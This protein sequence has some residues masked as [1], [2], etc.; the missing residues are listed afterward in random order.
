MY[1]IYLYL[2]ASYFGVVHGT[3]ARGRR[4]LINLNQYNIVTQS[5]AL[6]TRKTK[7]DTNITDCSNTLEITIIF[8]ILM[9]LKW[10]EINVYVS[11]TS[12]ASVSQ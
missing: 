2:I 4:P 12:T 11:T 1:L 9:K 5:A 10:N 7:T 6:K 3:A 8:E